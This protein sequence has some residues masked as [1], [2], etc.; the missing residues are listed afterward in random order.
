MTYWPDINIMFVY[1]IACDQLTRYQF[2]I[3]SP[4][5]VTYSYWLLRRAPCSQPVAVTF[6]LIPITLIPDKNFQT[7]LQLVLS[8]GLRLKLF[9][10]WCHF[11]TDS[12]SERG[13]EEAEHDLTDGGGLWPQTD[14]GPP[15]S[16]TAHS[17]ARDPETEIRTG[18][19][20]VLWYCDFFVMV[21]NG[22]KDALYLSVI[23]YLM[24]FLMD[25]VKLTIFKKTTYILG[26]CS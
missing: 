15:R 13:Y 26:Q 6:K 17:G 3:I 25:K 12:D 22:A 24:A 5:F 20:V 2:H 23:K 1:L 18:G 19:T 16:G 14:A 4:L 7:V 21:N 11:V 8:F 9:Y 10:F